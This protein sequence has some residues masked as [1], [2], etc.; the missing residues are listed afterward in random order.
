[1]PVFGNS[2][3]VSNSDGNDLNN[4]LSSRFPYE[5]IE[6]LNSMV[7]S[8]GDSIY[9]KSGDYWNG[10]FRLKGSGTAMEPIV[11]DVY[12]GSDKRVINGYGYQAYTLLYNDGHIVIIK[13]HTSLGNRKMWIVLL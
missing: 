9:F 12:G 1:M 7:F 11:V 8:S 4:G 2:S 10:M 5:S 6:I 3:Y 13:I